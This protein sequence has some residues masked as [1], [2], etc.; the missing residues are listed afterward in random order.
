MNNLVHY[1]GVYTGGFKGDGGQCWAIL[2]DAGLKGVVDQRFLQGGAQRHF[3]FAFSNYTYVVPCDF[4]SAIFL[5][6]I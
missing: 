2:G 4:Y 3:V 1:L 5:S 6:L